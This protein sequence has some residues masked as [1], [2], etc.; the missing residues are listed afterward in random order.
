LKGVAHHVKSRLVVV[1][2]D[3]MISLSELHR[4]AHKSAK[5]SAQ[6]PQY[7]KVERWDHGKKYMDYVGAPPP[8]PTAQDRATK[9]AEAAQRNN[10]RAA[11]RWDHGKQIY[12]YT[13]TM[14]PSPT[15]EELARQQQDAAQAHHL[16]AVT[17]M[18]H[19]KKYTDYVS[20]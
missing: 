4:A 14:P 20:Q 16:R 10:L 11:T 1:G 5:A 19:G 7:T 18:D 13:G 8:A 15:Q 2:I 6:A 12:D 17:R 3:R 9:R